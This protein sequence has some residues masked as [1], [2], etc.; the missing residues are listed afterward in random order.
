VSCLVTIFNNGNWKAVEEAVRNYAKIRGVTLS[1]HTGTLGVLK[2]ADDNRRYSEVWIAQES[3][4][5][6]K[7]IPAPLYY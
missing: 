7:K 1:I 4:T 6:K 5:K 3:K 2:L